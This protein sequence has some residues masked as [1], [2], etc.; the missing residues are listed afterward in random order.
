[1]RDRQKQESEVAP[2]KRVGFAYS[3]RD[4]LPLPDKG[5]NYTQH[6]PGCSCGG[7]DEGCLDAV[8]VWMGNVEEGETAYVRAMESLMGVVDRWAAARPATQERP[9]ISGT[10]S[11]VPSHRTVAITFAPGDDL[12]EARTRSW[13]ALVGVHRA[14][15]I[16][17]RARIPS[18]TIEGVVP[19]YVILRE[20]VYR[21]I[22]VSGLV[23]VEHTFFPDAPEMTRVE[24][25]EA[26]R[27]HS[28]DVDGHPIAAYLD[29]AHT[30]Q[31][32][33]WSAG[34][35][36]EAVLLAAAAAELLIRTTS[37]MIAWELEAI[38]SDY[39]TPIADWNQVDPKDL[40]GKI[41]SR[42]LGGN[43]SAQGDIHPVAQWRTH[44]GQVRARCIHFG[45]RATDLEAQDAVR[46]LE[47][48]AKHIK[49]RL[50]AN[51][52]RLPRTAGLLL[53]DGRARPADLA[54]WYET[55]RRQHGIG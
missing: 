14:I 41:L 38:R 6:L 26:L 40:I 31:T 3:L 22:D 19:T 36:T 5:L 12:V 35:Y 15:R 10:P 49:E 7:R 43:W 28:L 9:S 45:H 11:G 27:L 21:S 1:M 48:M 52:S 30:A 55:Y 20:D 29:L 42:E 34:Q 23:I 53:L 47:A 44:I 16:A 46:A 51:R 2:M 18:L 39:T 54:Q 13:E 24:T 50:D 17:T 32:H 37:R 4:L 33:A 25:E 8:R